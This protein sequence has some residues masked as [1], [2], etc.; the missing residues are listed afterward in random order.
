MF[1]IRGRTVNRQRQLNAHPGE[2]LGY[3]D[4]PCNSQASPSLSRNTRT[5]YLRRVWRSWRRPHSLLW[6]KP[7]IAIRRAPRRT[8]N[9]VSYEAGS[10]THLSGKVLRLTLNPV[11]PPTSHH[12]IL[13]TPGDMFDSRRTEATRARFPCPFLR[14]SNR[15]TLLASPRPKNVL[16]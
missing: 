10:V 4:V 15:K 8:Y 11:T 3:R 5:F 12:V 1:S 6:P 9:R 2:A 16:P 14:H 13:R 7:P